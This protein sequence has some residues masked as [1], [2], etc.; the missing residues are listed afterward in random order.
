MPTL[1]LFFPN[2]LTKAAAAAIPSAA[3][4]SDGDTEGGDAK[5]GRHDPFL[6]P[7]IKKDGPFLPK[8]TAKDR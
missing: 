7:V 3:Y 8:E 2:I 4:G 1:R 5:T 6:E